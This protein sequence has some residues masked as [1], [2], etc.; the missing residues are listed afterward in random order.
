MKLLAV[1][2]T[3]A[4]IELE[5]APGDRQALARAC[6]ARLEAGGPLDAWEEEALYAF[7]GLAC[8]LEPVFAPPRDRPLS[9]ETQARRVLAP[10]SP[11]TTP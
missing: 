4:R 2:T 3:P 1:S 11:P 6:L 5:L 7:L 9:L 10:P 8:R